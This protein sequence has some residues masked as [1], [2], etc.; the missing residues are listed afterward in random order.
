MGHF[1]RVSQAV[2][3][4]KRRPGRK[5]AQIKRFLSGMADQ[6]TAA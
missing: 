3:Q 4:V 1:T 5:Q 6:E 2:G